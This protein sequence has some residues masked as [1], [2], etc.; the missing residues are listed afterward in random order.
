[1]PSR[2]LAGGGSGA[3]L[4]GVAGLGEEGCGEG[5]LYIIGRLIYRKAF[6]IRELVH[7]KTYVYEGLRI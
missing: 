7:R 5:G 1:M 6:F 3:G 2:D 4:R